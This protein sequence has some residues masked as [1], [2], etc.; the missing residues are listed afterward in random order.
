MPHKN[1]KITSL[2]IAIGSTIQKLRS[3]TDMNQAELAAKAGMS[4]GMLSMIESGKR[5][6]DKEYVEPIAKA[7]G[8]DP[9]VIMSSHNHPSEELELLAGIHRLIDQKNRPVL[10]AIRA[11]INSSK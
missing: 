8:V 5:R 9:S 2:D 1:R 6:L 4:R 11:L 3:L 7:L 10:D